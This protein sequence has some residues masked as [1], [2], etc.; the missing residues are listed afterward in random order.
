[1]Q[2]DVTVIRNLALAYIGDRAEV[3]AKNDITLNADSDKYVNNLVA[4]GAGG[5][6]AGVAG[7]ISIIVINDL[8]DEESLNALK[9]SEG[10]EGNT[11]DFVDGELSQDKITGQLGDSGHTR[12]TESAVAEATRDL[13]VSSY[14][15]DQSPEALTHTQAF[16][17]SKRN[18]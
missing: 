7:A 5:G 3:N 10:G 16:I 9:D 8:M 18:Y 6:A 13:E 1:M 12:A 15:N 17:R 2:L 14:L 11:A 4:A